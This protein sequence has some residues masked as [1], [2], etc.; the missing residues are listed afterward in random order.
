MHRL[1]CDANSGI[2]PTVMKR[3]F[4]GLTLALAL[5]VTSCDSRTPAPPAPVPS[6]AMNTSTQVF[7]V[8]GVVVTV[9]LA[10]KIV[11][12]RHEEIP[13]YMAAMT[14]PFEVKDT[15]ELA[16]V[17]AG[18]TVTFRML[19]TETDGWIDQIKKVEVD[20]S[21]NPL[22]ASAPFRIVR[23]VEPLEVGDALPEYHFTNQ[24][25]QAVSLSQFRGQA[26]AFTFIF[27]RCPF[28][29]FCPLMSNNLQATQDA[30]LKAPNAPNNW[31]LL[32]I[33]FDPEYD[34]PERLKQY[35]ATHHA[36]PA[37][38][39]FLTGALIDITALSEQVG[40]QFW[41]EP[42][43]SINHNL[44]TVVVDAQGRVQKIF[45]ENKWTPEE[46]TA[47]IIKASGGR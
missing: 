26:L 31:H 5:A 21:A 3:C 4:H 25:G 33:S 34:T 30:L 10:E 14:M 12:I 27:T 13:G 23:D 18:D 28:P 19:V 36:D 44:R 17:N 45:I 37:R 22:P 32:T 42:G 11:R 29:T 1:L 7:L 24:L 16:G 6:S 35:A 40:L 47:E 43:G 20:P 41:R 39:E 2:L 8:K 15:D 9:K 46:L 38:W